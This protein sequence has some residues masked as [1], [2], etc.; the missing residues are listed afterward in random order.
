[1]GFAWRRDLWIAVLLT[2]GAMA[3]WAQSGQRRSEFG[4]Y[5]GYS[6]PSYD[7]YERNSQYV[8]VRDGTQIA[9]DVY[10]PTRSGRLAD[11]PLPVVWTFTPYNR[12]TRDAA[13][14]V[15][16]SEAA[17]L[18]LLNYGYALAIADVRG[19]GA[20]F[21]KRNGPADANETND[22]YDIT[23]WLAARPWSN[24]KVG[25]MGCSY[26]GATALQGVR[27][28]APH[29]KAAFV[30]TT[31][32]DQ[33]GTFAQGGITS[34]GLLDD[35]VSAQ[36][37]VEVDADKDRS[38]LA[39]AFA[40]HAGNTPTGRFFAAT[41]F[42]DDL[43]P[44]TTTRWWEV[45]SFYPYVDKLGKD[46]GIYVY[47]GYNDA[48]ADQTILKYWNLKSAKKLAFGDWPHC[49]TPGFAVDVERLRFFDYWLKGIENGV[50]SEAP[51]HVY[52]SRAQDGREW[53]GLDDWPSPARTRY[54]LA[55]GS[56][57]SFPP[58]RGAQ[59][60]WVEGGSLQLEPPSADAGTV[61]LANVP[62]PQPLV[63]YGA[64]RGSVD[65]YSATFTLPAQ[66]RWREIV[67]SPVLRLWVTTPANDADLYVYLEHVHR[68][69]GAQVI[70]RG[71]LRASHRKTGQ[72][73]Y[74]TRGL[75]W[76]T[77]RRA[78]VLPLTPGEAVAVEITLSPVAYTFRKGD[79][80]R[81]AVTTRRPTSAPG[82][83]PEALTIWS[84]AS[85]PSWIELPDVD[86]RSKALNHDAA[87]GEAL[88]LPIARS[89]D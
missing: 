87:V 77:H 36:A 1:M 81:L 8:T 89:S 43:N 74:D 3:A 78:D 53:R 25:M 84:D 79:L 24:G 40:E 56:A 37:V 68:L 49:E 72:A 19:K 33:Y 44:Y 6:A 66:D 42:R 28:G 14:V 13:G 23:E 39:A 50:M 58:Q 54:Y 69:G 4:S 16:A 21:G 65:P 11:Q 71:V 59:K 83:A 48:Y 26:F 31:M 5:S 32:F 82:K 46:V 86:T 55:A 38:R 62:N 12:A 51:V 41:P 64:V 18:G 7:G 34:D 57:N 22:A 2:M 70:A 63:I 52:V 9:V 85:H 35:S 76:Q 30:G 75:P 29:L 17:Q 80:L 27:S 20:S 10:R 15:T 45:G 67:G 47:G 61:V 73:P 88:H 60:A